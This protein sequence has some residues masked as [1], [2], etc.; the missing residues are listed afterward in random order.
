MKTRTRTRQPRAPVPPAADVLMSKYQVADGLGV[1]VT[2]LKKMISTGEYPPPDT[3]I[4]NRPKW[5]VQ[6]H[7]EWLAR[8]C[9][10]DGGKP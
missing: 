1:S 8:R 3:H 2:H 7:N 5:H 9:G 4:G 6:A 10:R